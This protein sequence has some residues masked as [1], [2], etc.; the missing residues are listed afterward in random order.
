MDWLKDQLSLSLW[1]TLL[2][3][4]AMVIWCKDLERL[5]SFLR[6]ARLFLWHQLVKFKRQLCCL[7]VW[8]LRRQVMT[9]HFLGNRIVFLA[10]T[11]ILLLINVVM[12]RLL[13]WWL[14]ALRCSFSH[15]I[16]SLPLKHIRCWLLG[17]VCWCD[18]LFG[19][20]RD[21]FRVADGED[22]HL[23]VRCHYLV[24]VLPAAAEQLD[25][26]VDLL[27]H[28]GRLLVLLLRMGMFA[29]DL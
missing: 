22:S 17:R 20:I 13:W 8:Y 4:F 29:A 24:I 7:R 3:T 12:E 2:L 21:A 19:E 18:R 5:L 25:R 26:V 27:A 28:R 6:G 1:L 10:A 11:V 15:P 23:R 16:S 9:K 14:A